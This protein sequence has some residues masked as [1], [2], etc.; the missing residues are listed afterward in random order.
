MDGNQYHQTVGRNQNLM[1][2]FIVQ[3][4]ALILILVGIK[5]ILNLQVT[6]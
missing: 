4:I 1:V 2:I 5:T 6:Y 3:S